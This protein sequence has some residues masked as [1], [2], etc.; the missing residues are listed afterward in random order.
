MA[1]LSLTASCNR[2]CSFCFA[3]DSMTSQDGSSVMPLEVVES[4]FDLLTESG[5]PEARLL[6]GEPTIHPEFDR[7]VDR[8]IERGFKVLVFSGGL[9]PP[10]PLQKLASVPA[11]RINVLVNVIAPGTG[12]PSEERRQQEVF[13]RLGPR[14]VLGVTIDSPSCNLFFLID[15]IERYGLARTVRLGLGHPMLDGDNTC[16]HPRHYPEV[17]RRTT[18][19]GIIAKQ[20]DIALSFDCGWVPCMFEP[21]AM[22]LLG[23]EEREV[24]LRCSPIL[25]LLP[26]GSFIS[27]YPLSG[28]ASEALAD[29]HTA[30]SVRD[31]FIRRQQSDRAFM[32]YKE[33][34]PCQFRAEGKCTGGC[35]AAS[36]RRTR[37][38]EFSVEVPHGA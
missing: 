15:L 38:R 20:K 30:A 14:V 18:D 17:G 7:I 10:R 11:D 2:S 9:I 16:L 32:L 23:V 34:G 13:E 25:D 8:A 26:D 4:A 36:L 28:H 19:F 37:H 27:C 35:L 33:C 22:A 21:G 29:H 31:A 12:K 1:N 3:A 24:G 6:G 5:I